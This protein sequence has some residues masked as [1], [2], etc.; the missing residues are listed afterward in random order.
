VW[1]RNGGD[2]KP[3]ELLLFLASQPLEGV[4]KDAV[5][6]ALWPHEETVEDLA[7]RLR[8]LRFRLRRQLQQVPGGPQN[9]GISLDRRVL[10]IDPGIMH[11]DA[12]EFL[13]LVRSVRIN[14]GDDAIQRLEQARALYV[15]DLLTG[16][17]VRRYAWL[18]ER[19]D[20]GVSIHSVRT[21]LRFGRVAR[22]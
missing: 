18:D 2:A 11:S 8:Q 1:P 5:I 13:T 21:F 10:R 14:P 16:P 20:S 17:D 15:G 4:S 6:S 3:W 22:A 9:D 19:D 12:Q 7:H